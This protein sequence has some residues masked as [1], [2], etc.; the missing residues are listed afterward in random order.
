MTNRERKIAEIRDAWITAV[1]RK[2]ELIKEIWKVEEIES[3]TKQ[4]L[5][6][7][8]EEDI[9]GVVQETTDMAESH[10]CPCSCDDCRVRCRLGDILF[11]SAQGDSKCL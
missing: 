8:G 5:F 11:G 1:K 9:M 7:Y 2:Q 4:L 3:K 6:K 10:N